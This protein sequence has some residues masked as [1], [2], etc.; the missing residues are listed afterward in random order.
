MLSNIIRALSAGFY[1]VYGIINILIVKSYHSGGNMRNSVEACISKGVLYLFLSGILAFIAGQDTYTNSVGMTMIKISAGTFVMGETNA[2]PGDDTRQSDSPLGRYSHIYT[3]HGDPDEHPAHNVTISS[4]FY[5]SEVEVPPDVFMQFKASY[6]HS[7][8]SPSTNDL[9]S[10]G[11]NDRAFVNWYE[12]RDFCEWLS[13]QESKTYRLPTEAE[14]EY[15]AKAGVYDQYWPEGDSL[16][17][18]WDDPNPWGLK[19]MYHLPSEWVH[20]WYGYYDPRDQADPVGPEFGY[21]KVVR[22][23]RVSR[24]FRSDDHLDA[25]YFRRPAYRCSFPPQWPF[26]IDESISDLSQYNQRKSFTGF[27][28]VQGDIPTTEPLDYVA[29]FQ[30]QALKHTTEDVKEKGPDMNQPWFR[31]RTIMPIPFDDRNLQQPGGNDVTPQVAQKTGFWENYERRNHSPDYEVLDNGDI[32]AIWYTDETERKPAMSWVARRLRFGAEEWDWPELWYDCK[33]LPEH[34]CALWNEDGT[35]YFVSGTEGMMRPPWKWNVSTDNGAT[36]GPFQF[37]V[38]VGTV[39]GTIYTSNTFPIQDMF[40]DNSGSYYVTIDENKLFRSDDNMV[41]WKEAGDFPGIHMSANVLAD[42][43]TIFAHGNRGSQFFATSS[44]KGQTWNMSAGSHLGDDDRRATTYRLKS[45]NLFFVHSDKWVALSTNNGSS[46]TTKQVPTAASGFEYTG[47]T[48]DNNGMIHMFSTQSNPCAHFELNEAWILSSSTDITDPECQGTP[49]DYSETQ[50]DGSTVTWSAIDCVD[51]R[52]ILHGMEEHNY[53]GGA[54]KYRVTW[55]K[56]VR[57]GIETFWNPDGSLRWQIFH[58]EDGTLDLWVRYWPDGSRRSE[59]RWSYSTKSTVQGIVTQ[60]PTHLA[61]AKSAIY[62]PSYGAEQ[63]MDSVM[64]WK[65]G[66]PDTG[67][68]VYG[69]TVTRNGNGSVQVDNAQ[70]RYNPDGTATLTATPETGAQFIEWSGD[71][72]G[73]TNPLTVTMDDDKLII[74]EFSGGVTAQKY[75]QSVLIDEFTVIA[76][77]NAAPML[78]Y[79]LPEQMRVRIDVHNSQGQLVHSPADGLQPAGVHRTLIAANRVALHKGL[80]I[81]VAR[82]GTARIVRKSIAVR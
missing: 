55:D 64:Q 53:P 44:D 50:T 13:Q 42:G 60:V 40:K 3:S 29:P 14:W 17:T 15:C 5:I 54:P 1:Y 65:D 57:A 45:G 81:I 72:S 75:L 43:S 24:T 31:V 51:G 32:L 76:G 48:Q 63:H 12:A 25:L 19:G 9:R 59:S 30:M 77:R 16:A 66:S 2:T 36:W 10:Q 20:D 39:N 80:Y 7:V 28:I 18:S 78:H 67:P 73:T 56:G 33:S 46:W 62:N 52:Y 11:V 21:A 69:L 38:L 68:R 8:R 47:V 61:Q 23:G 27:R 82:F 6:D 37:P 70:V 4:D 41:T 79:R 26:D 22:G 74:A 49:A 71:A 58:G 34:S 35:L